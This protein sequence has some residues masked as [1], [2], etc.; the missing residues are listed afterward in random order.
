MNVRHERIVE[1]IATLE[2]ESKT[3]KE[4]EHSLRVLGVEDSDGNG[5]GTEADGVGVQEDLL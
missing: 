5:K 3:A 4:S 2:E 1:T